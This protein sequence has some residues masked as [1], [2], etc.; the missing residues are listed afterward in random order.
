MIKVIIVYLKMDTLIRRTSQVAYYFSKR[1]AKRIIL[2]VFYLFTGLV[3]G[4]NSWYLLY[5]AFQ[6]GT[7]LYLVWTIISTFLSVVNI[8]VGGLLL[9]NRYR[10]KLKEERSV[11]ENVYFSSPNDSVYDL[12]KV[13]DESEVMTV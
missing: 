3:F 2:Y 11:H 1:F 6:I 5:Y 4:V 12:I 8:V 7:F 9:L 13:D 10:M